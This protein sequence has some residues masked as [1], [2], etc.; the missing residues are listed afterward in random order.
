LG[1]D[2]AAL[3][4]TARFDHLLG[5]GQPPLGSGEVDAARTRSQLRDGLQVD[6]RGHSIATVARSMLLTRA[7]SS[8]IEICAARRGTL[9]ALFAS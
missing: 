1:D 5:V 2:N 9:G 4:V 7:R 3:V 8:A 6:A